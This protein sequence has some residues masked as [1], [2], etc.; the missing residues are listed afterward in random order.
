MLHLKAQEIIMNTKLHKAF[1]SDFYSA[2]QGDRFSWNFDAKA[3]YFS[4]TENTVVIHH[5]DLGLALCYN[6]AK[7]EWSVY[8]TYQKKGETIFT[9]GF[10]GRDFNMINAKF[11]AEFS[12]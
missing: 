3:K 7:R 6:G 11:L 8:R 4:T 12:K 5:E 1:G 9:N 10:Y 2:Y